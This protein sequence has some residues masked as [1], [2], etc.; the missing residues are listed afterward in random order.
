VPLD[1]SLYPTYTTG[2]KG[3]DLS[4]FR[5]YIGYVPGYVYPILEQ[6]V[7]PPTHTPHFVGN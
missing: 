4:I 7:V 2:T 3:L 1:P 5:K 6:L